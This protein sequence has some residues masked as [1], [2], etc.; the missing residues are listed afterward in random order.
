LRE[1]TEPDRSDPIGAHDEPAAGAGLWGDV[2]LPPGSAEA[3]ARVAARLAAG[4][5]RPGRRRR[6]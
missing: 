3:A 2:P 6:P 1:L 5:L 4:E